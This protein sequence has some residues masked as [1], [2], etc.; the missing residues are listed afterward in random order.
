VF[1]QLYYGKKSQ[2][3]GFQFRTDI[4]KSLGTHRKDYKKEIVGNI[5]S[6]ILGTDVTFQMLPLYSEEN[7]IRIVSLSLS[8][9]LSLSSS[10]S[11]F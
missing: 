1:T 4:K 7:M 5:H 10:L 2:K 9:S 3:N 8:L 6:A 11:F